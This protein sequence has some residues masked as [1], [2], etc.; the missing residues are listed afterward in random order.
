MMQQIVVGTAGHID[1]GKT[2]L[3]KAL[4]GTDTDSLPQEKARGM[5]IDLGFAYLNEDVTIIDVPGHEKFIRNMA[6]GAASV[7]VGLMV[8]AADDGI[9]P[10]TREH[11]EILNI[12]GIQKGIIAITKIDLVDD[13]EWIELVELDILAL[14]EGSILD[15]APICRV[16]TETGEGIDSLKELLHTVV[17]DVKPETKSRLFKMNVDRVFSKQGFGVIVT[18]TV[19]SGVINKN[20]SIECLP[21]NIACH[22]RGIQSHGGDV[23][24][25]LIGDRA[26]LN[27]T[28]IEKSDIRRGSILVSKGA[29][30]TTDKII[31]QIH[32]LKK[33]NW[34]I[35]N[36]QRLRLNVGTNEILARTNLIGDPVKNG[37]IKNI[38]LTL[39]KP[40]AVASDEPFV[41]RSYSPMETIAG[42]IVLD[43]NPGQWR[44]EKNK[45]HLLP[46]MPK[47]RFHYWVNSN[48]QSPKTLLEWSKAFFVSQSYILKWINDYDLMQDEKTGIVYS[49]IMEESAQK[50]ILDSIR[51]SYEKNPLRNVIPGDSILEDCNISSI[52]G[53]ELLQSMVNNTLL[54]KLGKG[55]SLVGY[56]YSISKSDQVDMDKIISLFISDRFD[57]ISIKEIQEI[58][59]LSPKR[60][61]DMLHLLKENGKLIPIGGNLWLGIKTKQKLLELISTYYNTNQLLSVSDFKSMTNQSRKGAI[62]LLEYCDMIGW[63]QRDGN[64]R[65]KGAELNE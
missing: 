40:I 19:G 20:D 8:I 4:T 57:P 15:G 52:W 61:S 3:V 64:V 54:E 39:E 51:I 1:H 27:L 17:K 24:Q 6:A 38:L 11:L 60:L 2:S 7:H 31:A 29:L 50:A 22:V 35:K 46:R 36:K 30:K 44:V 56:K 9:M 59:K 18:G 34:V 58:T 32:M 12:M 10:Q 16:S 49:S 48:W 37:E 43:S 41:I 21:G 47:D 33:T 45:I 62:P 23:E 14:T 63:T 65:I 42:G 5:T 53:Q 28:H 13:P 55:F 25:A 26:A